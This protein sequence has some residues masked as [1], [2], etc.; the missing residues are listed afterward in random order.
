MSSKMRPRVPSARERIEAT[1]DL[2]KTEMAWAKLSAGGLIP[3]ATIRTSTHVNSVRPD[4]TPKSYIHTHTWNNDSD[5][6]ARVNSALAS[7]EDHNTWA[8]HIYSDHLFGD[9][10][11]R[12]PVEHISSVDE[13]GK[14]MGWVSYR[15]LAPYIEAAKKH[16][17]F[18]VDRLQREFD[19]PH[20]DLG[21]FHNWL[22][23]NRYIIAKHIPMP[24]HY[25]NKEKGCFEKKK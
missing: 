7:G 10:K 11:S 20:T 22:V 19:L 24:G 23:K 3:I 25:F 2:D 5:F 1:P 18:M 13:H 21:T 8:R 17:V 6:Y 4:Q 12:Y 15:F 9:K 14:E 16:T